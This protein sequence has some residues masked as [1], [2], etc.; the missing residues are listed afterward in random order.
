MEHAG[1]WVW[2]VCLC[3]WKY[4]CVCVCACTTQV[5]AESQPW[6]AQPDDKLSNQ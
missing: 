3:V 1:V 4:V 2:V 6:A 5:I